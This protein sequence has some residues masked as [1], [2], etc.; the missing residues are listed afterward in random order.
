MAVD[1]EPGH[2][3][4]RCRATPI[5]PTAPG[6]SDAYDTWRDETRRRFG[7][8]G[9]SVTSTARRAAGRR[10]HT[11]A[12]PTASAYLPDGTPFAFDI[13]VG[14]TSSDWLSVANIISQNLAEVGVTG[15]RRTPRTGRRVV[16]GYENGTLRLRHRVE[17]QRP[18]PVP[19]LPRR[20]V[21]RDG[22]A[23]RRADV[24]ELP[25]LRRARRPTRC[26]PSS[27]RPPT[28]QQAARRSRTSCR[29][30][31]AEDAP[32]VPLFPG[33]E[34][35]ASTRRGSPAGPPRT[36]RTRRSSTRSRTTVL[37]LTSL[38]PVTGD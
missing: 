22:E 11:R 12:A 18:H 27:P 26:S 2:Q 9:R 16:A 31:F 34:W 19:V 8:T 15:H 6:L 13:S 24:R 28:R 25:P 29:Q 37:V 20:D 3:D 38:E 33:P 36:T 4:R 14:S 10:R 30:L 17:Q 32:V 7:C 5:P 21:D 23:G 1:R 35:G